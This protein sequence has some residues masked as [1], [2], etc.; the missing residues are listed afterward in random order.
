MRPS[1]RLLALALMLVATTTL[2]APAAAASADPPSTVYV[3]SGVTCDDSGSGT[4]DLPFCN[5]Q[6]A[7]DQAVAGQTIVVAPSPAEYGSVTISRSGTPGAPIT[8]TSIGK[9]KPVLLGAVSL[10]GV[11]DVTFSGIQVIGLG[12]T[13]AIGVTG[14]TDV[15][16]DRALLQPASGNTA[17]SGVT[18]D[19]DSSGVTVSKSEIQGFQGPIVRVDPGALHVTVT[20]NVLQAHGS[21][22]VAIHGAV[23][24]AVT[25][26]AFT[27]GCGG[28]ITIDGGASATVENNV[29]N[30]TTGTGCP[31]PTV[32]LSVDAD[33][34]A[35]VHA[36]YNA[37]RTLAPAVE[38]DWGGTTYPTAAA[39][40]TAT[41]QGAHDLDLSTAAGSI[42]PENSPL[43]DSAD[44][45]AP[46]E[47][48]TDFN[49]N[50]R[51]DDPLVADTGIGTPAADRGP[52][53]RQDL[54]GPVVAMTPVEGLAPLATTF[55]VTSSGTSP[56][57]EPVSYTVDFG[58]GGGSMP[59]ASGDVLSHTYR[60]PGV[61]TE[62]TTAADTGGTRSTA[63]QTV[64]VGTVA[65][66]KVTMALGAET[67]TNPALGQ[68]EILPGYAGGT[69]T[70]S[71]PWEVSSAVIDWGDGATSDLATDTAT[72]SIS[73]GYSVVGSYP[74]TLTVTDRLGRVSTASG[75]ATAGDAFSRTVDDPKRVYDSRSGGGVDKVPAGGVVKLSLDQL[76][77]GFGEADGALVNVT[78]TNAKS[79]GFI[80]VYPDGT[81]T[82]TTS[83]VDYAAGQT[84]ANHALA[85]AGGDG[86]VDFYNHSTGPVDLIV[87][88]YGFQTHG[89]V[90]DTY[91]PAGP[92]RVLDT[93]SG[94]GAPAGAVASKDTVTFQVAGTNGVPADAAEVVMNLTATDTKSA[95]FLTAY[96]HGTTRPGIS[97]ADWT[98]GQTACSLVVIPLTD[99]KVTL[100]NSGPG[101]ADFLADL[102]G[103][104]NQYGDASVFL[105]SAPQRLLDTR[106]GLGSNGQ[107]AKLQPGQTITLPVASHV[108]APAAGVSAV[109][110]NLTTTNE[111]SPG[112]ITAYP[113]G[114]A[115]PTTSSVDF[116]GGQTVA[117][118]AIVPVGA[119]GSID[120]Y[121]GGGATVD[122]L[123]DL[124]GGYYQYPS[125]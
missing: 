74:V 103:Y 22:G 104:Y 27:A 124:Y 67:F 58:D 66:P 116:A 118:M 89:E 46:G 42:P 4:E 51:A 56:W 5:L 18:I 61:Y 38:D 102:V 28:Y 72:I 63:T 8:F 84:V 12:G 1:R 49:G 101:T 83:N 98:T 57:N 23:D 113:H 76:N 125:N 100:Y 52:Y 62:T 117:N 34:A 107:I 9:Q 39:F 54:I 120:L 70:V 20:T 16:I 14:S 10:A 97:N 55:K 31:S 115:R 93:R 119:N 87:D 91:Q 106:S 29:S 3:N 78:V 96:A 105:P 30:V 65:P 111:S 15:T 121:N 48:S 50:P 69:V 108:N 123:V 99:G 40:Q 122:L 2:V 73:H 60:T 24:A 33:S 82:P 95:G 77:A 19:G 75:T 36:D 114:A 64:T 35:G 44:A 86:I 47:L 85:L 43:L 80:A 110:I 7:A 41:G 88:T 109:E 92:V 81:P 90:G 94:L 11:H 68:T 32:G 21:G 71:E 112:Y 59:V 13:A 37:Y 53:E 79:S 45:N 17:A 6:P 25:G 26:N